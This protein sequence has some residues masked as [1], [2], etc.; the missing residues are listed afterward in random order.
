[1]IR[2]VLRCHKCWELATGELPTRCACGKLLWEQNVVNHCEATTWEQ[3][4]CEAAAT[5]HHDGHACC[6]QHATGDCLGGVEPLWT[7]EPA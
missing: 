5:W 4:R 2:L 7:G 1:M 3:K 6:A